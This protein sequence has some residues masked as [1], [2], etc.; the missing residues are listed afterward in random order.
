MTLTIDLPTDL[1]RRVRGQAEQLGLAP[2]EYA[3]KVLD[4]HTP[5]AEKR[6]RAIALLQSWIDADDPN[7]QKDTGDFLIEALDA[8]RLSDRPLFPPEMKGVSW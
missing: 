6:D 7:E 3:L 4:Q 2:D 1:E 5:S 8:D